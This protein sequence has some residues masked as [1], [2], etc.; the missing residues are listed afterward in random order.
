MAELNPGDLI[1]LQSGEHIK[2]VKELGRGGQGIVYLIE[3]RGNK[4]ALKWYS[5]QLP[6]SFYKNLKYNVEQGAPN[7]ENQLSLKS[8]LWPL[9]LTKQQYDSFG[10]VMLLRPDEFK[11][12]GDFILA[13]TRFAS[14]SAMITAALKIC[15][16]FHF[17]HLNGYSYQD[18]NDGNFFIN[19]QTGDLLICD[20][21]NV[22]AQGQNTGILGK[23][24]YMAPEIVMGGM[25]NKYSDRFSLAV[26][27]FLLFYQN[28]P[29]EGKRVLSSPCMTED[30]DRK[31]YG[32]DALFIFDKDNNQNEPVRGVHNNVIIRW[33]L[34]TQTLREIFSESFSQRQ[35]KNPAERILESKWIETVIKLRNCLVICE[36]CKKETFIDLEKA[37]D[38][39]NCGKPLGLK[40]RIA[41]S[42]HGI[43]ALS[44][45]KQVYFGA[46]EQP[47]AHVLINNKDPQTWLLQ[48]KSS[49]TWI[50]ETT[51]GTTRT[52]SPNEFM[53]TKPG[54]KVTFSQDHKGEII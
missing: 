53:P 2:V 20:N 9:M 47:A 45:G 35:I 27:L 51:I 30:L 34:F 54:L 28:H 19:P 6:E 12:F 46:S 39:V 25:P 22:T 10:Y 40:F 26:I 5:R 50:V 44:L 36:S 41:S 32:S 1:D 29:L 16:G 21:D 24:R 23:A 3:F 15:Q 37:S 8:F 38:C 42:K 4:Y 31:H 33:P 52:V 7:D 48:N 49:N 13:K 17:L 18:L 14:L 11:D 43:I